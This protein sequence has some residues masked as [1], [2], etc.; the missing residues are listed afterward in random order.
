VNEECPS[1]RRNLAWPVEI[2]VAGA[3]VSGRR[4]DH[5]LDRLSLRIGRRGAYGL[6]PQDPLVDR[7][8]K[9][10]DREGDR[11]ALPFDSVLGAL[12]EETAEHGT[13]RRAYS[14]EDARE[15]GRCRSALL[16]RKSVGPGGHGLCN[17]GPA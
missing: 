7:F 10:L 3:F 2:V 11:G 1:G 8:T 16:Q 9:G 15:Q 5:D 4:R 17:D 14:H 12:G 13:D 6:G